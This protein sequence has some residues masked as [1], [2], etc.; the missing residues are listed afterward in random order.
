MAWA[1]Q[2]LRR[3]ALLPW[4]LVFLVLLVVVERGRAVTAA[5]AESTSLD[6][7]DPYAGVRGIVTRLL[8]A[9]KG[10]GTY[11]MGASAYIHR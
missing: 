9:E 11:A 1:P 2:Q 7:A 4:L 10:R 6:E 5:A 8:G 3:R